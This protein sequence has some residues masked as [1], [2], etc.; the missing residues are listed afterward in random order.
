MGA[1]AAGALAGIKVI[2]LT[3]V[4][5]GPFATQ[6]LGDHGADVIKIE[7]PEGD[8]TRTW[9]AKSPRGVS[10]YFEG[11]NRSK[12]LAAIDFSKP[13]GRDLLLR[14]LGSADVLIHN[15]KSGTLERW[16]LGYDQVLAKKYP[17]LIYC[18]ITGFGEDG[19]LGG[20]PGYD[21]IVQAMSGLMSVNG[22]DASG[23][24][25]VGMPI[26]DIG[27][28][29]NATIAILMALVERSRSGKGQKLDIALYDSALPFLHPYAAGTMYSGKSPGLIG[30]SH[31]SVSPYDKYRTGTGE[32]FIGCGNNRQ[33][34]KLCEILGSPKLPQDPRY[35]TN[36]DRLANREAL[37]RD[38]EDLLRRHDAK[39][40]SDT[41]LRAG[42]PG[43]AVLDVTDVVDAPHTHHRRMRVEHADYRGLGIPVKLSRTPGSV[44]HAPPPFGTDT[45]AVCRDAGLSDAE[46]EQLVADKVI[47]AKG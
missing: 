43:G 25:R 31:P 1:Q 15:F 37:K 16:G 9:G 47:F 17:K 11:V 38:L 40:L 24:T 42:V 32:I 27:T 41:L 34:A 14:L 44:R 26:V 23:R 12:R 7:P 4:L 29:Y 39:S 30:N 6:M 2:D 18:H 45:R 36:N 10:V 35:L 3:R 28:G 22:T 20:L 5:G 8:E 19:P 33:F 21:A 46:I 13:E